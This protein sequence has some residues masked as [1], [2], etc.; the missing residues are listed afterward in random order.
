MIATRSWR[1]IF[2]PCRHGRRFSREA[3]HENSFDYCSLSAGADVY[4]LWA[5]RVPSLY[6]PAA[7][8]EPPG[9]PVPCCRKPVA[10]CRI[11]LR[12]AGAWRTTAAL[13]LFHATCADTACCGALQ[14][15]RVSPDDGTGQ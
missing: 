5:E 12:A 14:H 9:D 2:R 8:G 4:G 6:P 15:P 13:R 3:A 1:L 7:A 11:L 10:F